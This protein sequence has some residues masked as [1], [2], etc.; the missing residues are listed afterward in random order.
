MA[1]LTP[2]VALELFF[3]E[4]SYVNLREIQTSCS[5]AAPGGEV[6][7]LQALYHQLLLLQPERL[8]RL[9]D[10]PGL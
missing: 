9:H 7:P 3:L 6:G 8:Q 4:I 1:V 10:L 2:T 5:E